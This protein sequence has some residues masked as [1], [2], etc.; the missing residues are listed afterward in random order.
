MNQ[1]TLQQQHTLKN[2]Y[3]IPVS[4][5]AHCQYCTEKKKAS[6]EKDEEMP[7]TVHDIYILVLTKSS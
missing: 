1:I 3:L 2:A 5:A 7:I 4:S 6:K